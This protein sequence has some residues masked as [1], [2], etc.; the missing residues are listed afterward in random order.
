MLAAPHRLMIGGT[1]TLLIGM[2]VGVT[3]V[4][5]TIT[6]AQISTPYTLTVMGSL[7]PGC[8]IT[9]VQLLDPEGRLQWYSVRATPAPRHGG[10]S[11]WF[12][13]HLAFNGP[14]QEFRAAFGED[15]LADARL[16]DVTNSP[17]RHRFTQPV[18][19]SFMLQTTADTGEV[20]ES[21]PFKHDYVFSI[22]TM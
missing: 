21:R 8:K 19:H 20:T 18:P 9:N 10:C 11:I 15:M 13:G 1:A 12:M 17:A 7:S 16:N 4:S 3:V 2:T 5:R 6:H 14:L 22:P